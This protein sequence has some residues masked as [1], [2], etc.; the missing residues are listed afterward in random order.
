MIYGEIYTRT[1]L[2]KA[3]F[4]Y[5]KSNES[6]P[7]SLTHY[8]CVASSSI[9]IKGYNGSS[10]RICRGDVRPAH[11]EEIELFVEKLNMHG[12]YYNKSNRRVIN[13]LTGELI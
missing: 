3:I 9:F 4:A 12:F 6:T 8:A 13:I 7:G 2:S 10:G 5:R 1:G 11:E